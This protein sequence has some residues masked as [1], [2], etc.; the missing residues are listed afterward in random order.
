MFSCKLGFYQI[1]PRT[2]RTSWTSSH[3][4][5][6]PSGVNEFIKDGTFQF[7]VY[8]NKKKILVTFAI[9]EKFADFSRAFF[10][11]RLCKSELLR[12]LLVLLFL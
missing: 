8:F 11:F 4:N 5:E 3:S 12:I 7:N 1:L 10:A 6:H 9:L 2:L